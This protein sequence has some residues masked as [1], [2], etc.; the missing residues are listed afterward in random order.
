MSAHTG[1]QKKPARKRR[2]RTACL[3]SR[4]VFNCKIVSRTSQITHSRKSL[5]KTPHVRTWVVGA[6]KPS[7]KLAVCSEIPRLVS[8]LQKLVLDA[9]V[10]FIAECVSNIDVDIRDSISRALNVKPTEMCP[11]SR[12]PVRRPRLYWLSSKLTAV[13][14]FSYCLARKKSRYFG[15]SAERKG[16]EPQLGPIPDGLVGA[17]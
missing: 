15:F 16:K 5:K 8:S 1:A 2:P 11:S 6:R 17:V 3:P 4:L 10:A 14:H 13:G 7:H 12:C 9:Q